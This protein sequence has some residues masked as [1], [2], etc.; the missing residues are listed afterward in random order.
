MKN[1][2][3]KVN[4]PLLCGTSS[5]HIALFFDPPTACLAMHSSRDGESAK[6]V[7]S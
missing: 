2:I 5:N 6:M 1:Q 3:T 7:F 4:L